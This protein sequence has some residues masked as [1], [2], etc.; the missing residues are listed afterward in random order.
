MRSVAGKI[1]PVS[2]LVSTHFF[3]FQ[4]SLAHI[5]VRFHTNSVPIT[6][7]TFYLP[8]RYDLFR[9]GCESKKYHFAV[10]R[11]RTRTREAPNKDNPPLSE[12]AA[13]CEFLYG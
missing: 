6:R 10:R 4:A 7:L 11:A 8:S 9:E 5:Q 3:A 12:K 2:F 1:F 13:P